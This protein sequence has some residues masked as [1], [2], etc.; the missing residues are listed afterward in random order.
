MTY[1][2]FLEDQPD[3]IPHRTSYY[4]KNWGFCVSKLLSSDKFQGP[5]EVK[6]NTDFK[7]NGNLIWG[8]T[9]KKEKQKMKLFCLPIVVILH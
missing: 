6:I 3:L 1:L 9:F 2:H 8:E 4:K 5:F 7:K